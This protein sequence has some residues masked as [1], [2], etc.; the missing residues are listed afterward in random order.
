MRQMLRD[1][2][3]K[4]VLHRIAGEC[5]ILKSKAGRYT[6]W[7]AA[8]HTFHFRGH[9]KPT[10]KGIS[11]YSFDF[12]E[13][14]LKVGADYEVWICGNDGNSPYYRIPMDLIRDLYETPDG[15]RGTDNPHV[16][17]ANVDI[18][19]HRA[20]YAR[21]SGTSDFTHYFCARLNS[22]A[23]A[24]RRQEVLRRR[25]S[26]LAEYK[27]AFSYLLD[28]TKR[29]VNRDHVKQQTRLKRFLEERD[30]AAELE[31]DFID[32]SFSIGSECFIGEIKV[33]KWFGPAPAFRMALGQLLDYAYSFET[34]A[35]ADAPGRGAGREAHRLG[36]LSFSLCSRMEWRELPTPKSASGENSG[37]RFR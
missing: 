8:N 10:R 19:T 34:T 14:T 13:G 25:P 31:R 37:V 27:E 36:D 24:E 33:T 2:D 4:T 30:I 11:L 9:S 29:S 22:E 7:K 16:H 15:W 23:R 26:N 18:K 20:T 35:Y 6:I 32:I 28:D 1:E 3:I 17:Q 21:E 12:R 5:P